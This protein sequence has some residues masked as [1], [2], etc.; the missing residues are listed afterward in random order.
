MIAKQSGHNLSLSLS[1]RLV[2]DLMHFSQKVP[3]VMGERRLKLKALVEARKSVK[4]RPTWCAI[5]T[6]AWALTAVRRPE[7]RR[8]YLPFPW[9]HLYEHPESVA[10]LTVDRSVDGEDALFFAHLSAPERRTFSVLD[11]AIRFAQEAPVETITAFR[12]SL[13]FTRLPRPLRRLLWAFGLYVSGPE[14]AR[15][16]GTFGIIPTGAARF[17]SLHLLSP[18]TSTITY[19]TFNDDGSLDMRMAADHRVL[20]GVAGGRCLGELESILNTEILAEL[21]AFQAPRIAA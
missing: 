4:P 21:R 12:R 16:F 11:A 15:Y 8:C 18:L 7:L 10:S 20:D 13:K 1:R 17:R 14:R 2:C 6:K 3:M 9:P 19:D 5:L